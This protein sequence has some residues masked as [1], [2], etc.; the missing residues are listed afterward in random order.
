M[1]S[2]SRSASVILPP[3]NNPNKQALE[4]TPENLHALYTQLDTEEK[5]QTMVKDFPEQVLGF[6]REF[7]NQFHLVLG[8][9]QEAIT[10]GAQKA[11]QVNQ[12]SGENNDLSDQI[13]QLSSQCQH[14]R[15][16]NDHLRTNSGPSTV[17][18]TSSRSAKHPDPELYSGDRSFLENFLYQ[19][20]AK[21]RVNRD[22]FEDEDARLTYAFGRLKGDASNKLL[23]RLNS[24]NPLRITTI[25]GFI[26]ALRL[27]YGDLNKRAT[28]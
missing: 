15:A 9:E 25:D 24:S 3:D 6:L 7:D 28:A 10:Q 18:T 17:S 26:K 1:S 20:Q 12:L 4:P 19:L 21:L 22:W 23:P 8:R 5:L 14:L 2:F 16:Q 11:N 13:R 27:A